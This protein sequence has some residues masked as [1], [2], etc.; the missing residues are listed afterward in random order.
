L[1]RPEGSAGAAVRALAARLDA[2]VVAGG[3]SLE[4]L[5]PEAQSLPPRDAP[6]LRVLLSGTLRWHHRLQWLADRLL[7]RPLKPRETELAALL[8]VGLFQLEHTRIPAHAAVSATV[9]ATQT[10]GLARAR[11]LVNAVLRRYLREREPLGRELQSVASARASHPPWIIAALEADWPDAAERVLAANNELPPMW[12]RVNTRAIAT[13]D[14]RA[15]LAAEGRAATRSP[16]APEALLLAEPCGV[17]ELPGFADGQVSVQ[18]A[19][20]QLAAGLMELAPGQR[21]LDACAAPGGKTAHMLER[22]PGIEV[23][24][25]DRD[26]ERLGRVA[27]TLE[28]LGLEARL[29]PADASEPAAWWDGTPFDRILLD[30]PCSGLGVIRRHPDIKVLRRADDIARLTA[31]QDALL[32]ALWPTLRPGG[33][34]VYATCSVLAA[35]NF[36]RTSRFAAVHDDARLAPAGSAT[37]FQVLPGEANMDGFYYA[38]LR[39]AGGR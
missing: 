18:D 2:R 38:C 28:R 27:M 25:L 10:L 24:A 37:H 7:D 39:K 5:L 14:Y 15:R 8:R 34:L 36:A 6:L 21:V 4:T 31:A 12:L 23:V 22:C 11:G 32:D 35:E 26:A 17:D 19:A 30:A 20:A 9:A 1:S 29:L 3:E 16:R 13:E 33:L